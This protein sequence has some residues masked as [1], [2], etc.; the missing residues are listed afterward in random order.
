MRALVVVVL[1]LVSAQAAEAGLLFGPTVV[2]RTRVNHYYG[3]APSFAVAPA[4]SLQD[5][6]S[7]PAAPYY[8][9]EAY[10][11]PDASGAVVT[12]RVRPRRAARHAAK[13]VYHQKMAQ[14]YGDQ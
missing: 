5:Y 7:A 13:A 9:V 1:V 3:A 10:E 12:V 14:Y 4:Q 8:S 2:T 11:A 6:V